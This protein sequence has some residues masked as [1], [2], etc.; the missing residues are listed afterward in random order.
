MAMDFLAR[1]LPRIGAFIFTIIAIVLIIR[2]IFVPLNAHL[3]LVIALILTY[4]LAAYIILPPLVHLI[5]TVLRRGR[6]PTYTLE[7][8]GLPADPVNILLIGSEEKIR[9][10]FAEA[11]WVEAD[12]LTLKTAWKMCAA[13]VFNKTYFRAPFRSL[14]LFGRKQ[15]HGFQIAIGK[16]PRKRHHI[17]VWAANIDPDAPLTDFTYWNSKHEIDPTKPLIWVG[18]ATEDLGIGLSSLTYQ[19][20]H[21]TDK[22]VDDEREYVLNSLRAI[23][24]IAEEHYVDANRPVAGKYITDGRIVTAV[25]K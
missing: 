25:L 21:R 6:I 1:L 14:Y 19:I 22:Y 18:A 4:V 10:R 17:R 24:A 7:R 3:P 13:Y 15:D 9:E 8:D 20:R 16:S 12:S 2:L 5:M 11:G 23:G